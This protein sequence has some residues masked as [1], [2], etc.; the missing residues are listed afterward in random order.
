MIY[1]LSH[2]SKLDKW[3]P[4]VWAVKDLP[5]RPEWIGQCLRGGRNVCVCVHGG[6]A[7]SVCIFKCE[8][9]FILMGAGCLYECLPVYLCTGELVAACM[10]GYAC[11][12]TCPHDL[13]SVYFYFCR[14][15]MALFMHNHVCACVCM[16][17][18]GKERGRERR[19]CCICSSL[20]GANERTCVPPG[21]VEWGVDEG[22][23][24]P[25][26]PIVKTVWRQT[27]ELD[28]QTLIWQQFGGSSSNDEGDARRRPCWA[29]LWL[30]LEKK[31]LSMT[32]EALRRARGMPT[33]VTFTSLLLLFL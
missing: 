17:V 30:Y 22:L 12:L 16:W 18:W 32:K 19:H 14:L 20:K 2:S 25:S 10:F 13:V 31:K 5:K 33:G 3:G 11:T 21:L 26:S 23:A 29:G 6:Y 9:L 7:H 28:P 15:C 1:D 4:H 24:F 8:D 27:W